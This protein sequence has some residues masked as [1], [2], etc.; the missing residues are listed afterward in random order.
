[1]TTKRKAT[2]EDI[3]PLFGGNRLEGNTSSRQLTTVT[4]TAVTGSE[5][6][7]VTVV[8]GG[9]AVTDGNSG[10]EVKVPTSVK[11][12]PGD[13]VVITNN[14]NG[15]IG[16]PLVTDVIGGGDRT[17]EAISGAET[18]A[19]AAEKAAEAAQ[20]AAEEAAASGGASGQYFF[21]DDNGVHVSTTPGDATTGPNLLANSLG[22]MLRDGEKVRTAQTPSGFAV[23]DGEGN[24]ETNITG[25]FSDIVTLGKRYYQQLIVDTG[26]IDIIKERAYISMNALSDDDDAAAEIEMDDG[27]I[28]TLEEDDSPV[29]LTHIGQ[30]YQSFTGNLDL[31]GNLLLTPG[32]V[33][34]SYADGDHGKFS[35]SAG[36]NNYATGKGSTAFGVKN[37]A[38]GDYSFVAGQDNEA[39]SESSTALGTGS[40]TNAPN[41]LVIGEYNSLDN[42]QLLI[43]GNGSDDEHRTNAFQ[44]SKDGSVQ[45]AGTLTASEVKGN[46]LD[47]GGTSQNNIGVERSGAVGNNNTITGYNC[48]AAGMSN[49]VSANQSSAIGNMNTVSGYNSLAAGAGNNVSGDASLALGY[50]NIAA[51]SYQTVVGKYSASNT[52]NLFIVGN[53]TSNSARSNAFTVD[54]NGNAVVLKTFSAA[55]THIGTGTQVVDGKSQTAVGKYNTNAD[56]TLFVVGNGTSDSARS[57]AMRVTTAGNVGVSGNINAGGTILDK[58]TQGT[59]TLNSSAL[60]SGTCKWAKSG[61][62]V[63]VYVYAKVK[64]A[65]GAYSAL[66]GAFSGLPKGTIVGETAIAKIDGSTGSVFLTMNASGQVGINARETALAAGAVILGGFTY[67]SSE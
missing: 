7:L 53:G 11:V 2:V 21:D 30:D 56:D 46:K 49:R 33:L 43:V 4:G 40:K 28:V 24:Q 29:L 15:I 32:M 50:Y 18:A 37:T 51:G 59:G 26:G 34:K 13:T 31:L 61:H 67:V 52:S 39:Q 47:I 66:N 36:A 60:T 38:S 55:D 58:V 17:Y 6:G 35:F 27:V 19:K 8:I 22:I 42:T 45:V 48:F 9:G 65:L 63:Q 5:N 41:Q 14:G 10:N 23:Y 3:L 62:I 16:S 20:K 25:L 64:N 1:M 57:N 54:A 12:E 44:V